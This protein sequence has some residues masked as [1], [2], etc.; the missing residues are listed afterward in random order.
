MFSLHGS[1][2][3]K[4]FSPESLDEI[5]AGSPRE[6]KRSSQESKTS[7]QEARDRRR[8]TAADPE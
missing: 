8:R 5:R 2:G 4:E 7:S 6:I 1:V 3:M